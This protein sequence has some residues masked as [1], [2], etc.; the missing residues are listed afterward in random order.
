MDLNFDL[1]RAKKPVYPSKRHINLVEC[2]RQET[3]VARNTVLLVVILVAAVLFGKFAVADVLSAASSA[4]AR[5]NA[6]QAE[7]AALAQQNADYAEL[8]EKYEEYAVNSLSDEEMSLVDRGQI[9]ALLQRTVAN[10]ADLQSVS[11]QEN[12]VQLQFANGSLEDV[13]NIVASLESE[14]LVQNVSV[15]TAQT[16]RDD[17]VVSSVTITL[18]PSDSDSD[19]AASTATDGSANAASS[20]SASEGSAS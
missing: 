19:D 14:P 15:S 3:H 11:I 8:Q 13:S 4:T 9:L 16:N 12:T 20:A 1:K 18:G 10:S 2:S 7:A 17:A 6:V 5:V